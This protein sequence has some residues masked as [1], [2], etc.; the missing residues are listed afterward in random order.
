MRSF[1]VKDIHQH[2]DQITHLVGENNYSWVHFR[3]GTSRLHAKTISFFES[4]LPTFIRPHKSF[5]VNPACV[6]RL[7][8]PPGHKKS[9]S[10][11]LETGESFPVSRRRWL[12]VTE[13]LARHQLAKD[14]PVA[15][16]TLPA[17]VPKKAN[18]S[19]WLITDEEEEVKKVAKLMRVQYSLTSFH[20]FP[21]SPRLA[22]ELGRSSRVS[23][24]AILLVDVR[25]NFTTQIRVLKQLRQYPDLRHIP[26]ILFVLPHLKLVTAGYEEQ[27][28]SVV[29]LEVGSGRLAT[30]V[31]RICRFWFR[32]AALP[33]V[34]SSE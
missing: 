6:K 34:P 17:P 12:Q 7:T 2:A 21:H 24:P 20:C 31:S 5:L 32:V 28:N 18:P 29:C 19:V 8:P 25:T 10:L 3:D 23:F 27:A 11:Q 14:Q 30:T 15:E 13:A 16:L 33:P 22:E 1:P 9:G 26:I 4:Y